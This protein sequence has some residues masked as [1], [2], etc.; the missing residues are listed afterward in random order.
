MEVLRPSRIILPDHLMY[1]QSRAS[2]FLRAVF[3]PAPEGSAIREGDRGIQHFLDPVFELFVRSRSR[4]SDCFYQPKISFWLERRSLVSHWWWDKVA[5]AKSVNKLLLAASASEAR[6]NVLTWYFMFGFGLTY[7]H[8]R[9]TLCL[10]FSIG[11]GNYSSQTRINANCGYYSSHFL[12]HYW[13]QAW[14]PWP[15]LVTTKKHK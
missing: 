4:F 2:H 7:V 15:D 8:F 3:C 6:L 5:L 13:N 1:N 9:A 12:G 11:M 10:Q 14:G